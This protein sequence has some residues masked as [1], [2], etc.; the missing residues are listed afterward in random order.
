MP[1][2][3]PALAPLGVAFATTAVCAFFAHAPYVS[4]YAGTL[5]G[6]TFLAVT[7]FAVLRHDAPTIRRHGLALGG[8]LEPEPIRLERLVRDALVALGWALAFAALVFPP[9]W[10]GW[11]RFWKP[12]SGFSPADFSVVR[13]GALTQLLAIALPEEAFYRGYLQSRLD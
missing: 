4:D 6:L 9:F 13:D 1:W 10:L 5:I 8:L 11:L 3:R 7:Y 12:E 2:V